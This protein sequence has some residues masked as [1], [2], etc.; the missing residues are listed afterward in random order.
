MVRFE[1]G[2]EAWKEDGVVGIVAVGRGGA[3]GPDE[4]GGC[5]GDEE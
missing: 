4:V 2:G 1:R 3:V 5:V